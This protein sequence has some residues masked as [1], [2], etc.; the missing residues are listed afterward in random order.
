MVLGHQRDR[1]VT[2]IHLESANSAICGWFP[3]RP[4]RLA[5]F[6]FGIEIKDQR[7]S[8]ERGIRAALIGA[9]LFLYAPMTEGLP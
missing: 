6:S 3:M 1:D 5:R 4:A 7:A 8:D 2:K 9:T